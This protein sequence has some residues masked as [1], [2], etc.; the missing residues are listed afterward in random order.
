VPVRFRDVI[1][2]TKGEVFDACGRIALAHQAL[3]R[4][5]EPR[6][7]TELVF[8]FDLMERRVAG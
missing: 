3:I 1:E 4:L 8:V 5:G 6:T 7:A 2:L